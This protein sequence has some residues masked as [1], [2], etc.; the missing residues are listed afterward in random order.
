[1]EGRYPN[2]L[3]LA[4]TNCTDPSKTEEFNYWYN[5]MHVPDVTAP[6]IFRHAI[7]F[8]NNDPA[9]EAG[10]YVCHLRDDM[11][12]RIQG[13]ARLSGG[14]RKAETD[15]RAGHAPYPGGDLWRLQEAGWRVLGCHQ[16]GAGESCWC[17][18]IAKTPPGNRSSTAGTRMSTSPI[19]WTS[20]L[21]TPPIGT[22]ASTQRPPKP[23]IW[24]FMKP[25]SLTRPRRGKSMR[26]SEP[27]G[28]SGGACP[29]SYR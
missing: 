4:I 22:R 20:A 7:R 23:N 13:Q 3:Q 19:F 1:M 12:G 5:H 28:N 11:G 9:S 26:R 25:T 24:P 14:R 15:G 8:A 6:G 29:I 18:A 27:T 17:S 21:F 2:G 16:A 10:Q